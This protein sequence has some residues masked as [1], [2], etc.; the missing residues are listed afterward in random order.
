MSLNGNIDDAQEL[1]KLSGRID[2]LEI[3]T[4]LKNSGCVADAKAVGDAIEK[5]KDAFYLDWSSQNKKLQ[6]YEDINQTSH[7]TFYNMITKKNGKQLWSGEAK[8]T[9][10]IVTNDK[11]SS[12]TTIA[13]YVQEDSG[14]KVYNAMFLKQ[15][16]QT[17]SSSKKAY[18]LL[19]TNI[20]LSVYKENDTDIWV[21]CPDGYTV[22][23][24]YGY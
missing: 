15:L 22:T 7:T 17:T 6:E 9:S 19:D 10:E 12:H 4:T 14:S 2:K 23:S 20:G 21:T 1:K 11:W 16:L 18:A 8:G 5:V 3:D 13:L 24:V